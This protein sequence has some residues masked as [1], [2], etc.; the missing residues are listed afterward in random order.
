GVLIEGDPANGGPFPYAN[1]IGGASQGQRNV[2]AGNSYGVWMR[3]GAYNNSVLGNYIGTDKDG[4]HAKPNG[5]GVLL[6]DAHDNFIGG[7]DSRL[8]LVLGNER[9]NVISASISH[10]V[11]IQG[12][13]ASA[14]KLMS[15][16]IGVPAPG[17]SEPLGNGGDGIHIEGA[18][19]TIIGTAG[20][21][22]VIADNMGNGI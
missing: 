2:I 1:T 14:N 18:P 15:N 12:S 6:Q 8:D 21:G 20:A 22:N 11:W 4:L 3:G 13:R 9:G 16:R 5:V 17:G 7:A 19:G 10:G